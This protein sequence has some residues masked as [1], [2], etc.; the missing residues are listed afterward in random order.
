MVP[1]DIVIPE[2]TLMFQPPR[3]FVAILVAVFV[4]ETA[5][6]AD[7]VNF[8]QHVLPI[9]SEHC[10]GCHGIDEAE[11]KLRLDS[12]VGALSGGDSGEKAV[13]P[14]DSQNS[15]LI[16]LVTSA[17]PGRR[18][19]PEADALPDDHVRI[20]KAWI[21]NAADWESAA[22]KLAN[23]KQNSHW[24]FR[25]LSHKDS[26][27]NNPVQ[28]D[29]TG[30]PALNGIDD[31][32]IQ[33]LQQSELT[34]SPA[35]DRRRL[36]R[37]L[38]LVMLGLPPTPAE[39]TAFVNDDRTDAWEIL[40]AEVLASPHY[41]ERWAQ[42][43][44]DLV[45]FGETDGYETNRERPNA[46]R[47][48]DWVIDAFNNDTPYDQFVMEQIAG[49]ALGAPVATSFLVAGPVDIVKGSNPELQLTQRQD[50]LADIVNT[51]STAFLGLTVGCARCHDH[52]FDPILQSDYYSMQ[53]V[54]AGVRHG[55]TNLPLAEEVQREVAEL[56]AETETLRGQ[57]AK[58]I[59]TEELKEPVNAKMNTESFSPV[60]AKF[61]R[62]E[63]RATNSGQPCIDELEV[64]AGDVNVAAASRGSIP[65]SSGDFVHALHKLVH[66][67]DGKHGNPNSWISSVVSG[68]WV[69]VE[70]PSEATIDRIVW[71][72]DREG[73]F[74][75]RVATDYS[76]NVSVDGR[77]WTE[78][79]SSAKR[80]PFQTKG[81]GGPSYDFDAFPAEE[82]NAGRK[83][84]QQLTDLTERINKLAKPPTAYAGKFSQPGPTHRLY[85]GEPGAPREQVVPAAIT[86]LSELQLPAEAPEQQRR[87]AIAKWIASEQ[88]PLTARVMVNR[89]WQFHFGTGFVDTPSDFGGNG[90]SPTHP[91]LLDWLAA[92]FINSGW[93]IKHVQRLI[94]MS[95]TWQQDSQPK[96]GAM[97]IDA[98]SRLLWRFPPRR[99][100]AEAIR[101]CVLSVTDALNSNAGGPGFSAF[102]VELEN[103]RHYFPKKNY[104]PEDWRRMVYQTKVRQERDSVFG[105]FDCPDGSQVTPKRSRSTT[106]LQALNLLNSRFL[107]QQADLFVKR[108][109]AEG[110]SANEK[111]DRAYQLCFGR[112]ADADELKLATEFTE[113]AG[114][115]QFARAML[116]SNEFV[117]IP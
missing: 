2:I 56:S 65:T 43:W 62:F 117:F 61:V 10:L 76:I 108:L 22:A 80:K 92:E 94:L 64:F 39:V 107:I 19:P 28:A 14:G 31:F 24:A 3:P 91:E 81:S 49:D 95:K 72:R 111:V 55:D 12:M 106:P 101:D 20:L 70:F 103:V 33:K 68:G 102:E 87:L 104:G 16:E 93:S 58:F 77:Q 36:I 7:E 85:R 41:G 32:I 110:G 82:A 71:G 79:A 66:I 27:H 86:S 8:Q 21:D 88:N 52:K 40:V 75:D 63:I 50:E 57:L 26:S 100:E 17:D 53:A 30:P 44:L 11:S 69:Q 98:A 13:V 29:A 73:R 51:T 38:Y 83:L 78:V 9:L 15:Y 1:A 37:R 109:E 35:A 89:L 115:H 84:H 47:Y 99:L 112:S 60:P 34:L 67:N 90:T 105:V 6:T 42:H 23:S 46:W 45:R 116:N 114:W 96:T 97:K 113:T 48:R 59:S 5:G 18:M 74:G 54:F 25:P 4:C